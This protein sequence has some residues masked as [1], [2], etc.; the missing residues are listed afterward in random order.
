MGVCVEAS[1]YALVWLALW[2]ATRPV[3]AEVIAD[4]SEATG[5]KVWGRIPPAYRAA[6]CFSAV[7]DAYHRVIP[8]DHHPA[9]GNEAGETAH[10]ER[11]NNPVRQ[12]LGRLGRKTRSCATSDR[13]HDICLHRFL[14]HYKLACLP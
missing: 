14:H 5:R 10:V 7:W 4:R 11:W 12:R 1:P 13:M 9:V 8:A 3:V 2:R 6:Q